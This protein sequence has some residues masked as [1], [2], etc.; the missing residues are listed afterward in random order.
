VQSNNFGAGLST[1][2][3]LKRVTEDRN[4]RLQPRTKGEDQEREKIIQ[5][6]AITLRDERSKHAKNDPP[7][8]W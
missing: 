2:F 7:V 4:R 8:E 3:K 6:C 5:R 1:F